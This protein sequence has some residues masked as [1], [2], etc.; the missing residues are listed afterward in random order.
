MSFGVSLPLQFFLEWVQK[1]SC[2]LFSK[3]LI[4]FSCE[5]VWSRIL[6]GVYCFGV[7]C[8]FFSWL[9]CTACVI[10]VYWT[11]AKPR[12]PGVKMLRHNHRTTREFLPGLVLGDCTFWRICAF[13]LNYPFYWHMV[14]CSSHLWFFV[15]LLCPVLIFFISNAIDSNP[16][17]FVLDESG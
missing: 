2:Y 8:G 15:F 17:P 9:C 11:E 3:C 14:A 4:E 6:L 10:P 5:A 7:V 12:L 1:G 16:F 13:L